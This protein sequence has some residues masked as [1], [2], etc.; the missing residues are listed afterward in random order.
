MD[1]TEQKTELVRVA[2]AQFKSEVLSAPGPVL[3][4]FLAGWSRACHELEPVL[5]SIARS[6]KGILKV[7]TVDVDN[8]LDLGVWYEIR[9]IPTLIFFLNGAAQV[10][11][12]GTAT[13]EAILGKIKPFLPPQ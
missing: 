11:I 2:E 10:R 7:V 3:V 5:Q 12:V 13:E 8:E 9:S 6:S 4:A 1:Q